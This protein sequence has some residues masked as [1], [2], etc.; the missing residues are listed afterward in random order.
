MGPLGRGYGALLKVADCVIPAAA[1]AMMVLAAIG[2]TLAFAQ[3]TQIYD[4]QTRKWVDYDRS[5]AWK[6]YSTHKEVPE[7][8]RRQSGAARLTRIERV[9]RFMGNDRR[10]VDACARV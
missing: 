6:Y 8:F 2:A 5:K 1:R 10:T 7:A 9:D 3:Q 4:A